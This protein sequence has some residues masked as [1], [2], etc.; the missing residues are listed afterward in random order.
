MVVIAVAVILGLVAGSAYAIVL[1]HEEKK[2]EQRAHERRLRLRQRYDAAMSVYPPRPAGH[3][4]TP[5][6]SNRKEIA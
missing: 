4:S 1:A 3:H 6:K 2:A 5:W